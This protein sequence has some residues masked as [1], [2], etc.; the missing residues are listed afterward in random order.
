MRREF[1]GGNGLICIHLSSFLAKQKRAFIHILYFSYIKMKWELNNY[2]V[3]YFSNFPVFFFKYSSYHYGIT[4][5][6]TMP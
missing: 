2:V 6:L 1:N 5:M 4:T 3:M